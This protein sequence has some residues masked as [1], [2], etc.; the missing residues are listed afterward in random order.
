MVYRAVSSVI[1][2]I[3]EVGRLYAWQE[4]MSRLQGFRSW[5][6]IRKRVRLSGWLFMSLHSSTYISWFQ[7]SQHTWRGT[8]WQQQMPANRDQLLSWQSAVNFNRFSASGQFEVAELIRYMITKPQWW[9]PDQTHL[10]LQQMLGDVHPNPG[11]ATKNPQYV[12]VT[13]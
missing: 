2:W 13:L 8:V 4:A 6:L 11:P 3:W 10:K 7:R 5:N 12:L 1:N 9:Q